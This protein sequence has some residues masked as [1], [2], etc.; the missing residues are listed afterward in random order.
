LDLPENT[1]RITFHEITKDAI[2]KAIK[3]P[4]TINFDLVNAQQ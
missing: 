4:R 3:N 2:T 1:P